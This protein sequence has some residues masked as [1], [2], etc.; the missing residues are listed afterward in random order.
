MNLTNIH[1]I[2]DALKA[3]ETVQRRVY[4]AALWHDCLG[5][6]RIWD[7]VTYE[8]RTKPKPRVA[9]EW[10]LSP[11]M[12][13]LPKCDATGGIFGCIRVREVLPEEET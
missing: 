1:E 4:G 8:F 9:R 11:E 10:W 5:D 12:L 3:G 7:L 13:G 2:S 6:F